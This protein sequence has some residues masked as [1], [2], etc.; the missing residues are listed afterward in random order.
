[1]AVPAIKLKLHVTVLY[2][3]KQTNKQTNPKASFSVNDFEKRANLNQP[4]LFEH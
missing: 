3:L 1:M 4:F 2:S